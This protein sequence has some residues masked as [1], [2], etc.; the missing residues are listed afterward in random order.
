MRLASLTLPFLALLAAC[1]P[2]GQARRDGTDWPGYGGIDENHYSPLKDI[3][4]HNVGRLGLAWYQ[5]IDGG[6][7]S[8]TAP[9]AVDGILYYASGYSVVHAVDAATGHEL[10]TYDPQSWKVADQKMRGAWGSRGIAYDNGAVYVGTIDGRLIA[11]N[12]RTG[13]RLWSTQTIGKDDER[14]ISGAPW[15]FNGKVLIGHGG[16]DF[17]PIRGYVTAYDQKTG[18]QLWRFYTVPGDPKL[19]FEN[20]AMAMAAK[21]WTGEWWKYGGGGTAWNAMAYDPKYNRIYIG[22]GNGSPWNQKI[23]SPGGGDNLF[24][25]SIVALDADTGEYVWHYQTNPGETWD[26]N[27][28]MDMELARLK[29]DGRE[30]DVLMHAPKNG[31]F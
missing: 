13:H 8:L 27:S 19:G 9:I 28:A 15:V 2:S 22:V 31:F 1:A 10:W 17:A 14:Y 6:G 26:F 29:I 4:G 16:A 23:R 24:L 5:D 21:T 12:A 11:I 30:R 3:N 20:K 25:C 7:S 18:K